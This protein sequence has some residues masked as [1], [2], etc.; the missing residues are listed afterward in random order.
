M[1]AIALSNLHEEKINF[2]LNKVVRHT[3]ELSDRLR[4]NISCSIHYHIDLCL[5]CTDGASFHKVL[6]SYR[7]FDNKTGKNIDEK[8]IMARIKADYE[9]YKNKLLE[10]KYKLHLYDTGRLDVEF[11]E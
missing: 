11:T 3:S 8:E 6:K 1:V 5:D 2:D 4:L 10:G 7:A 9:I